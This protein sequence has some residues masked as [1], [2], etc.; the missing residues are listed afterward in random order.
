M[1]VDLDAM[2]KAREEKAKGADFHTFAEGDTL[3]YICPPCREGD[4]LPFVEVMVN[5]GLK[6]DKG[7]AVNLDS[8]RNKV[9]QHDA[10]VEYLT[11]AGKDIAGGDPVAEYIAAGNAR[12]E[13]HAKRIKAQSRYMWNIVPLK[14]RQ[15]SSA[16]WSEIE[17]KVVVPYMAGFSVWDGVMEVF[18]NEGD[19]TDPNRPILVRINRKGKGQNDTKY[20]VHP[21]SDS[22][23]KPTPLSEELQANVAAALAPGGT[24]DLYK[25]IAGM[26]KSRA[27]IVAM[28]SG[29]ALSDDDDAAPAKASGD[30]PEGAPTC[31]GQDIAPNDPEC[32]AC[33]FKEGCAAVVGVAVPP[34]PGAK[35][36][37]PAKPA[38]KPAP[39]AAKPPAKPAAAAPPKPAAPAAKPAPKPAAALPKAAAKPAPKP[40]PEP[41]VEESA[42]ADGEIE[43]GKCELE[44]MYTLPD[45]NVGTFTGV[46]KGL[47]YFQTESGSVKVPAAA[48]VVPVAQDGAESP[49]ASVTESSEA[50]ATEAEPELPAEPANSPEEDETMAELEAMLAAKK[51]K[52]KK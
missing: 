51:A 18:G 21:D 7:M 14:Y 25:I 15:S 22:I 4:S 46:V 2:R 17:P 1:G 29:V 48:P 20:Q 31:Y 12:N 33:E 11:Q 38:A 41:E 27:D 32:Q 16:K 28:L 39:A 24:G 13:E 8:D 35:K 43:A 34:D 37:P 45:G 19:I 3:C 36:A 26:T 23:R 10:L 52:A 40:A 50:D 47:A 44:A 49:D 9:L 5:Y 6:G 42:P 30:A